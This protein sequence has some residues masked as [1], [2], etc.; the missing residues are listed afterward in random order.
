MVTSKDGDSKKDRGRVDD[1]EGQVVE[2]FIVCERD[3]TYRG[4]PCYQIWGDGNSYADCSNGD[5]ADQIAAALNAVEKVKVLIK[6]TRAE[7]KKAGSALL[8]ADLVHLSAV[9][10]ALKG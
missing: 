3:I 2:R 5:V 8:L 10:N 4:R 7:Y 9:E 6:E 1:C